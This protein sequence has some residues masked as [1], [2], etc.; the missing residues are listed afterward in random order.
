M[1]IAT[2][3][4]SRVS[5]IMELLIQLLAVYLASRGTKPRPIIIHCHLYL[6]DILK[7]IIT[8]GILMGVANRH[9]VIHRVA[10]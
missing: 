6:E 4:L 10:A 8:V 9:G 7:D 2:M 3:L 1:I 5:T